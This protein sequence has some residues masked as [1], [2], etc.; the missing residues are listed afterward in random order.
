MVGSKRY[1]SYLKDSFDKQGMNDPIKI[2]RV[3][4]GRCNP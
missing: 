4:N 3:N 1:N 2:T